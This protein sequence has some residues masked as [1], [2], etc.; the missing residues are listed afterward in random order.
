MKTLVLYNTRKG[1]TE[2]CAQH[3]YS[4]LNNGDVFNMD[5][6]NGDLSN[7]SKI[8]IGSPVYIGSLDKK[9][10]TFIENNKQ[11]LLTKELVLFI[12]SMNESEFD[13]ML[14]RNLSEEIKKHA[15]IHCVGGAYYFD[16]LN[17]LQ[18]FVIK[19]MAGITETKES[20]KFDVLDQ[21]AK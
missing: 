10:K 14:N 20:I 11:V 16:K 18:K 8:Y 17:W 2:K 3:I 13:D 7:Y 19:K 4:N 21:I 6:F 15:S 9:V 1:A 12:C 5:E